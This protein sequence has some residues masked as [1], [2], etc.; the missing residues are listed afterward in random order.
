MSINTQLKNVIKDCYGLMK[1]LRQMYTDLG[2]TVY[3]GNQ[4]TTY[5]FDTYPKR[6]VQRIQQFLNP[7]TGRTDMTRTFIQI[8]NFND[9]VDNELLPPGYQVYKIFLST[10]LKPKLLLDDSEERVLYN[11]YVDHKLFYGCDKQAVKRK[12]ILFYNITLIQGKF[13]IYKAFY[14]LCRE[15]KDTEEKIQNV[16]D[17]I[18]RVQYQQPNTNKMAL[19]LESFT[20]NNPG[21]NRPALIEPPPPGPKGSPGQS[22][23]SSPA[24]LRRSSRNSPGKNAGFYSDKMGFGENVFPKFEELL[25]TDTWH[26]CDTEHQLNRKLEYIYIK[27]LYKYIF[28]S[29]LLL[30]LLLIIPQY[31][32][33]P[34]LSI[35]KKNKN[36]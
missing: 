21:L 34:Y 36:Y 7:N 25:T 23:S 31:Y 32:E 5:Y 35:L 24:N 30:I 33:L 8:P 26:Q 6:E 11:V 14:D 29:T 4:F 18:R 15:I 22:S 19:A 1:Q 27:R 10:N 28:D 2:V 12:L 3:I 9:F 17:E 13:I 20:K 16:L